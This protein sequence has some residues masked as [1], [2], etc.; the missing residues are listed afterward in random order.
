MSFGIFFNKLDSDLS[1]ILK[2]IEI[3]RRKFIKRKCAAKTFK[4][5]FQ[6]IQCV[7][8]YL[9][10]KVLLGIKN[11]YLCVCVKTWYLLKPQ[12]S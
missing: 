1:K 11:R 3:I 12:R 9:S 5:L 6:F 8:F 10:Q 7:L 2:R 4:N